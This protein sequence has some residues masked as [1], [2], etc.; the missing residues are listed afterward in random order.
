MGEPGSVHWKT[1]RAE[2]RMKK[3]CLWTTAAVPAQGFQPEAPD[4]MPYGYEVFPDSPPR[5]QK[6]ICAIHFSLSSSSPFFPEPWSL[7]D[8]GSCTG[9]QTWAPCSGS[10]LTTRLPGKPLCF[11]N[12]SDW[13]CFFELQLI[14]QVILILFRPRTK[15]VVEPKDGLSQVAEW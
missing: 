10:V 3:S 2:L 8:L 7:W 11:L 15:V 4:T 12:I 5:L 9:N 13:F 1:W 6:Q 14:Q